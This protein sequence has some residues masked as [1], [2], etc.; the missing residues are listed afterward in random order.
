MFVIQAVL[1]SVLT[2]ECIG[3]FRPPAVPLAVNNPYMSIWSAADHLYDQF[4]THWSGG[5]MGLAGL[6]CIDGKTYR[7]MGPETVLR[8][9]SIPSVNQTSV[10][11][12]PT[13]TIY[14]FHQ[15]GIDLVVTFTTVSAY[16]SGAESDSPYYQI[17]VTYLNLTVSSRDGRRHDVQLYYDNSAEPAVMDTSEMVTWSRNRSAISGYQT[18]SIG[19]V[20]QKYLAQGSD[21]IN[22]GYW[23]TS[24]KDDGNVSTVMTSDINAR[25]AFA[26]GK[27]FPSDD[28]PPRQ[29]QDDWPVLAVAW[30]VGSVGKGSVATRYAVLAYDQVVSIRYFGHNMVPLWRHVF[31][32]DTA[33]MLQHA[34]ENVSDYWTV[35]TNMDLHVSEAIGKCEGSAANYSA[36][37][38]LAWRQTTGGTQYVWNDVLQVEWAFLKE[39][40]SD[41]DVS[42][43][44]V[45]YPGS[46]LLV[47][48][49]TDLLRRLLVPIL[50]YA[51]NETKAYGEY[52]PYNLAWAPHHLGHWPVCDLVPG[53]QEQMPVEETANMLIMLAA[54]EKRFGMNA[55]QLAYLKPYWPLLRSW[56]DYLI[57]NLPD[58]GNQLCT[59]DFEG[60]SP[61]NVN[62][63]A[64]G[65]VGLGALA[66]LLEADNQTEAATHYLTQ[67][68]DFV[69]FWM[70]NASDGDH[71]R[72]QYNLPNSW[73]LKYNLMY[74]RFLGLE[75]FPDSVFQSECDYYLE[76]MNAYGVPLD[77][78]AD[79]T[80]TDWLMW[81]ASFCNDDQFKRITDGVYRFANESPDRV[82][83][84]DWYYTSTGRVKGFRARPVIGGIFASM[85]I[86][87]QAVE[88]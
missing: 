14:V 84:S 51:N 56:G 36:I 75:L 30:N 60:P 76:K 54:A 21:R 57:S 85:L 72:L 39:I 46:P 87:C 49:F 23:Y 12:N 25:G 28:R 13:T 41:G 50:A 22:W 11:V 37:A 47:Y 3:E 67:A 63:A 20:D 43:V 4:P 10:V 81:V 16:A 24:V 59:D 38:K 80:K 69:T 73:S 7:Y 35:C 66:I 2:V 82:P 64:K 53:H 34:H 27:P 29:C 88:S 58:P 62:L 77:D 15:D 78:R 26:A 40:S 52:I 18:M 19:T 74:Q 33:A 8:G 6:V 9:S 86:R 70:K 32:N 83:F 44:D 79:F 1:L 5:T 71:Y 65:I 48:G 42:T 55:S 17:P 68:K 31:N 61:H 45:L